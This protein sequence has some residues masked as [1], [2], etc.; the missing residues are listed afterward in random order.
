MRLLLLGVVLVAS[1]A[2]A[3]SLLNPIPTSSGPEEIRVSSLS[4]PKAVL[5]AQTLHFSVQGAQHVA[6]D[7]PSNRLPL[8]SNPL[9]AGGA[10]VT[11]QPVLALIL[12]LLLGFGIGHIVAGDV[13]GFVLFLI[14]DIAIIVATVLLETFVSPY[15]GFLWLGLLASHIVQ[16]I[17]AYYKAGGG[18]MAELARKNSFEVA[19]RDATRPWDGPF[20]S[21][22]TFAINF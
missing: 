13:G 14:V 5:T 3:A 4:H 11:G 12:G 2:F 17:D 18:R 21:P 7:A 10:Y 8:P 19:N 6:L 15:L 20:Y 16:G 1:N 9:D 22:K